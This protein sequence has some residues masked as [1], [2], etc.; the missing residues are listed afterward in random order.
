MTLLAHNYSAMT[1]LAEVLLQ[2]AGVPFPE[3]HEFATPGLRFVLSSPR[4]E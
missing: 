3:A 2:S 1:N 4:T